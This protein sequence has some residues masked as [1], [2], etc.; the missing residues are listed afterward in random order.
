MARAALSLSLIVVLFAACGGDGGGQSAQEVLAETSQNL[1]QIKSGDLGLE[2]MFSAN[3]GERAGFTLEGPFALREG[4]LPQAQ[5]DY[6]QVAGDRTT[7][8]TFIMAGDKAY[9]SIRGTTYELPA[10]TGG[11]IRSTLGTSGGFG[12]IDLTSW[13]EDPQ[14]EDGGEMDGTETDHVRGRL[15]VAT[16]VSGLVAIASQFGGTSPLSPLSGVSGP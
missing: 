15:D 10:A 4:E 13:V 7:T 6:T 3:G 11:Q 16:V 14:L 9:V 12:T 2:L 1:G 8:Q 5:L